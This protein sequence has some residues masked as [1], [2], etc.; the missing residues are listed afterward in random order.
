MKKKILTC[1]GTRPNFIKITRLGKLFAEHSDIEYKVLHTGQ[2]FDANMSEIFFNQLGIAKPD[3]FFNLSTG[4]SQ[5]AVIAEII[6]KAEQV[7]LEYKP[8]LVMVPGDVNSS[9]ACALVASR[10]GIPVA[11]IESGLR[12]FD[13][14]MPEEVNRILI[15][16]VADLFFVTE[17][18]GRKHLLAEGKDEKK[19]IFTGNTMIDSLVS[20]M[21]HIDASD[22][23]TKLG[24]EAGEYILLTFHRP[25]NVDD[26]ES[27]ADLV[28]VLN[29][30]AT[31]KKAVF[32]IHPRTLKNLEK[33]GLDTAL[34]KNIILTEPQGY[35]EFL[36][37]IKGA[38]A[39]ITD[40]GGV[41][42]E[43]TYLQVPCITI[44]PNTERPITVD[45]GT[46]TMADNSVGTI[47]SILER[48]QSGNYKK[49]QI[50]PMWDGYSSEKIV[51]ACV[52][53]LG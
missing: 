21:P 8:D 40:S 14:T 46:N 53:F 47:K 32:P 44:R 17:E 22:I 15:D 31:F 20:F 13:K 7:I 30:I 49:G 2:H 28:D 36:S 23:K 6:H 41:Q 37:L 33:F 48:I 3:Y 18:S 26:P 38:W 42:E 19:I 25:G 45:L 9:F 5:L 50:P 43:T 51:D 12:S 34:S 29:V 4:I 1:V 16:D 24:V 35:I 39:V 11:H 27:L 10:H 52:K